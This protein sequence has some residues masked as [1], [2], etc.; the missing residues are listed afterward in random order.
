MFLTFRKI[1]NLLS[2]LTQLQRS[3]VHGEEN[4]ESHW[5]NPI[6]RLRPYH[7]YLVPLTIGS[8]RCSSI[9][10]FIKSSTRLVWIWLKFLYLPSSYLLSPYLHSTFL[11]FYTPPSLLLYQCTS[12]RQTTLTVLHFDLP[13]M[14]RNLW[15]VP[16]NL[17]SE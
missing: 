11:L 2:L 7:L 15:S 13:N 17:G 3:K 9:T 6:V 5:V 16:F 4:R 8:L 12:F 1:L 14:F 10:I